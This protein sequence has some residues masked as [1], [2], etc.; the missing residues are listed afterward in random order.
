MKKNMKKLLLLL[1]ALLLLGTSNASAWTVYF[2]NESKSWGSV[3]IWAYTNSQN[4]T[5][6]NWPGNGM[7][8]ISDYLYSY[9]G[10]G[11]TPANVIFS[12]NGNDQSSTFTFK[13]GAVYSHN[14][15]MNPTSEW[16]I[17]LDG[18][19]NNWGE[20]GN[21]IQPDANGNVS[22]KNLNIGN[23]KFQ[24]KLWD[25]VK[26]WYLATN[27]T[28]K[29]D[30]KEVSLNKNNG[31]N[32]TISGAS[33]NSVYD[34]TYNWKTNK[35][36][37]QPSLVDVYIRG[38]FTGAGGFNEVNASWKMTYDEATESYSFIAKG[39]TKIPAGKKF[40]FAN[41]DW[42][43]INCGSNA[44]YDE[45]ETETLHAG[46]NIVTL[47]SDQNSNGNL[48]V[49]ADFEGKITLKITD[50][51]ATATFFKDVPQMYIY[52]HVHDLSWEVGNNVPMPMVESGVYKAERAHIYGTW[53][54]YDT[55]TGTGRLKYEST[56]GENYIAFFDNEW[57]D[58]SKQGGR[59]DASKNGLLVN[60]AD[61]ASQTENVS[62]NT[63]A[64][65]KAVKNFMV[66]DG[67][68]EVTLDLNNNTATFKKIDTKAEI[69]ELPYEWYNGDGKPIGGDD[70][71]HG[72]TYGDGQNDWIQVGADNSPTHR[73]ARQAEFTV[74]YREPNYT[75]KANIRARANELDEV[76][77][78][79]E[80]YKSQGYRIASEEE[81]YNVDG[82][83]NYGENHLI[84]LNQAGDYA[85]I[86]KLSNDAEKCEA[87]NVIGSTLEVSVAQK[88]VTAYL[89][90]D[91]QPFDTKGNMID[92]A[93]ILS[94]SDNNLE[95]GK[96]FTIR[97]EPA[98]SGWKSYP[99]D[100]ADDDAAYSKVL[101]SGLYK[102]Y[103]TLV[104]QP[105][106]DVAIDGLYRPLTEKDFDVKCI[107][108]TYNVKINF[109]C[110]GVYNVTVEPAESNVNYAITPATKQVKITP[111]FGDFFG[112]FGGLSITGYS[113]DKDHNI[114]YDL[115]NYKWKNDLI[116]EA[117]FL[118]GTYFTSNVTFVKEPVT[119]TA[120]PSTPSDPGVVDGPGFLKPRK[121]N[122]IAEGEDVNNVANIDL[123]DLLQFK[124]S[125]ETGTIPVTFTVTKNGASSSQK[126]YVISDNGSSRNPST[127][128]E[129]V[130]AADEAEAVYYNLQGV[131]VEN[132][133]HGIY[134]KVVGGKAEKVVL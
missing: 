99:E 69:V 79:I 39:A 77:E 4:L 103:K 123:S 53:S 50:D 7:T 112:D 78:Q 84:Q 32:M 98:T 85:I 71:T 113:F 108:G 46:S 126:F 73:T 92:L 52:G 18:D 86:A 51:G 64:D 110:S 59:F 96:D 1:G 2:N 90:S 10:T 25:G 8:K 117:V 45:T 74:M 35:I 3:N 5:G 97:V 15:Q 55:S 83:S 89:G 134:V 124:D 31:S 82:S 6:T 107:E 65:D 56:N 68:Y 125:D 11:T 26:D 29:A 128:V 120:G 22:W 127:G 87:W 88:D 61:G 40:K 75:A 57:T 102:Q 19:F 104:S 111:N 115:T 44:G 70:N 48:A 119:S 131:R 132:P 24:I 12:N 58:V 54:E 33:A 95:Y 41:D 91:E 109:P 20:K 114:Y 101:T 16:Y 67:I 17:N 93:D 94:F 116:N 37:I 38:E 100:A 76:E 47:N 28:I 106:K 72:F 80:Y 60:P 122:A 105:D 30:G 23:T 42:N 36:T 27:G 13:D 21:G 66:A 133:E 34:V 49:S 129:G 121:V 130:E 63:P 118:P 9:T 81:E 43:V 62:W 14:K